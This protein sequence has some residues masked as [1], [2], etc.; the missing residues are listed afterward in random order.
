M[1]WMKNL[2]GFRIYSND[3]KIQSVG[4]RN[5]LGQSLWFGGSF[6]GHLRRFGT[7]NTKYL[8]V[9]TFFKDLNLRAGRASCNKI[10]HFSNEAP[11][12]DDYKEGGL[13]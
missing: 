5:G 3:S 6:W 9:C 10:L 11:E 13:L 12:I 2:K 8:H 7:T 4:R 1:C